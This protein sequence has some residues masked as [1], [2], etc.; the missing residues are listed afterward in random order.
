[1]KIITQQWTVMKSLFYGSRLCWGRAILTSFSL[2][3]TFHPSNK[4]VG[5]LRN[6]NCEEGSERRA[7]AD[8]ILVPADTCT[9]PW[10]THNIIRMRVYVYPPAVL[11]NAWESNEC[12]KKLTRF[13]ELSFV[14]LLTVQK[15][16]ASTGTQWKIWFI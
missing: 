3:F 5:S 4:R 9:R 16:I 15:Q 13:S 14:P 8:V 7:T 12:F 10:Q 11:N 1:M 6:V 2:K